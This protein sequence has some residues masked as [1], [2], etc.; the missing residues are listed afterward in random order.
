MTQLLTSIMLGT[1]I[2][3]EFSMEEKKNLRV[4]KSKCFSKCYSMVDSL[5][6]SS[7]WLLYKMFWFVLSDS[8]SRCVWKPEVNIRSLNYSLPCLLRRSHLHGAHSL[9]R[10]A[11][12]QG[13]RIFLSPSLQRW[14]YRCTLPHLGSPCL[15]V[16]CLVGWLVWF[17][18]ALLYV[19]TGDPNWGLHA[20]QQILHELSYLNS[21]RFTSYTS[22]KN[23]IPLIFLF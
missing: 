3:T 14:Y 22:V 19:G 1:K 6:F 2:P 5:F 11:G 16:D 20:V 13:T 9:P 17:G 10:L 8:V 23:A 4:R 7:I 12:Q 21:S 15:L 18:L